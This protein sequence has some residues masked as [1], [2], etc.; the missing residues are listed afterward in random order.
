MA[1]KKKEHTSAELHHPAV[2]TATPEH[3]DESALSA[4]FENAFAI[5]SKLPENKHE[6]LIA[7]WVARRNAA[8]VS[9]IAQRDDAPSTL[10]KAARRAINVLKSRGV[11]I[12]E[13]ANVVAAMPKEEHTIEARAMF[14]DGRGAQ[15]WWIAKIAKTGRT[16]VVEITT[17][18]RGGV[19]SVNRGNPTAGNLRQ[20]WQGW[21]SRA[22]RGP[23]EV[24]LAWARKRIADARARTLAAKQVLPMGLDAAKELL[25]DLTKPAE[26]KHP[27]DGEDLV[28]P[29]AEEAVKKRIETSMHLHEE[30]EFS[31]WL[32]DDPAGVALLN[33]INERVQ[34]LGLV[35]GQVP[36]DELQKKIDVSVN[37]AIDE[38]ANAYFDDERK[39]L[40]VG[41]LRDAAWSLY[42]AGVVDRAV[43]AIL[44]AGAIER[45]GVISDRPSEI[46]FVRG[47]F[48]KLIA[49]AQQRAAAMSPTGVAEAERLQG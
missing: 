38:A 34:A 36:D 6:E 33:S 43:D 13:R 35:P 44:V 21:V 30:P 39:K 32:P 25:G 1:T 14:P 24:P 5:A 41:R 45:A 37:E 31:S 29:S 3:L 28:V 16:E 26:A 20:I 10:R 19:V 48:V 17:M 15:I 22:G 4:S 47:M 7:A 2:E 40:Y 11:A 46:P 8:A 27:I 23:S 18:D 42:Q 12:P 49:I 9:A